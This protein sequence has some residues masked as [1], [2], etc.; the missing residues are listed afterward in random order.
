LDPTPYYLH[1]KPITDAGEEALNSRGER[2]FDVLG[3]NRKFSLDDM[4][5]L[6]FD[7]HIM[8]SD[9]IVPLLVSAAKTQ[10]LLP[11][12]RKAIEVIGTWDGS[13]RKN[14]TAYTYIH[15]WAIQYREKFSEQ[16]FSR[17]TRYERRKLV[18]VHSLQEQ[19]RGVE[20]LEKAI[21]EIKSSYGS[22]EVPWGKINLVVRNGVFPLGGE[23]IFNVLHPDEGV[24]Q[25]DKTIHC[26]DGWGHL[27]IV[28]ETT[29]KKVWTL[30]PYGESQNPAS[31][32]YGDQARLHSDQQPKRFWFS[33]DDILSHTESVWGERGRLEALRASL[34]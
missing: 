6:A 24:E 30:L 9:V 16:S 34:Q 28:T 21:A 33:A 12:A 29:P 5:A 13:S 2:L 27:M 20:A 10:T 7:T 31:P 11:D 17:F 14:S 26:N 19:K 32:H 4:F 18:D 25:D 23:S 22:A 15:F 8:A 3:S 1:S